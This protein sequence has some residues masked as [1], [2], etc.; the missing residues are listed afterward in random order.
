MN[1]S[2]PFY[3][4]SLAALERTAHQVLQMQARPEATPPHVLWQAAEEGDDNFDRRVAIVRTQ[5]PGHVVLLAT[6]GPRPGV[7][8]AG[9]IWVE[10]PPRLLRL[11]DPDT[12]ARYRCA[13]SGRGAGKSWAF[14][15]ALVVRSLTRPTRVL[16]GREFQNSLS[17][18]VYKLLVDQ[19]EGLG[20]AP[21]FTILQGQINAANGS[22]FIFT[23]LRTN[24]NKVKS[25]EGIDIAY[26]EE[27]EKISAQSW[28]VLIPTV[29]KPGSEIWLG[30]NPDAETD[31]TYQRFVKTPPPGAI[32]E[33]ISWRD[34]PWFP[35]ELAAEKDYLASVDADAYEHVW[36]GKCRAASD[37][38]I[39]RGKYVIEAFEPQ[40]GWD[41]PYFGADWG[42]AVDPS[43]LLKV[44]IHERR[45]YVEFEVYA[46][47]VDIDATPALFDRVPGAR[48][49]RV[50]A[51]SA[52][53]ETIS[54]MQRHGYPSM[55]SVEKWSGSV[56][57]GITFLR[58]FEQIVVH[59]RCT[60]TADEMRLYSFK[61]DRLTGDVLP[62]A[63]DKFNHCMDALRYALTPLI[64]RTGM[65]F[66][67]FMREEAEKAALQRTGD[68]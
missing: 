7:R 27:A 32:V 53:P 18:S 12:K 46:V 43:T 21:W 25:T 63:L 47:G 14:A 5:L 31:P 34:N 3:M 56:E 11:L 52:R 67:D 60:H 19:I 41:G 64:R 42:F 28:Q 15:R 1:E 33:L 20:L 26:L 48:T 45:L 38:Q 16:C 49:H 36:E 40:P 23:G 66:F 29:R 13:Y 55:C 59:T 9:V 24:V 51:D 54:Y 10:L 39:F 57:D 17:E 61:T 22:E 50:R 37:A 65:G 68:Q 30:F 6:C 44:W 2:R 58:S 8:L 35:D 62:E 4:P